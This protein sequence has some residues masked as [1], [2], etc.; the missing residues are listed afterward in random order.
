[1]KRIVEISASFTGK[2]S[3][4]SYENSSPYYALKEVYEYEK[5][6]LMYAT[7]LSDEQV[8]NRQNELHA[9]CYQQFKRHA[10]LAYS[11]KI[12]KTYRNIRFY[13]GKDGVKYPSVT[14]IIG[15]DAD[16][17][18]SPE[19]L[20][21]YGARGTIIDKQVEIYLTTGQWKEPKDI[22]EIYP[23]MVT[24]KGGNLSLVVDD[25]NFIDFYKNYPFKVI[26]LQGTILN[27]DHK[28]G[29]RYDIKCII[30]STNKGKWEKIDGVIFDKPTILDVKSGAM[31]KTKFLKQQNAYSKCE[32][33]V[34]QFGIIHLNN[35]TKQGYS[36]PIIETNLD[37]YFS[38]FLKD[39]ENFRN[40][41]GI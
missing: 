33:D 1:M 25:I 31:D 18:V 12:A 2:I 13:D 20:A 39:R 9:F 3:T 4:G 24:L 11:E 34:V 7:A 15:W 35:E 22:P 29:G 8:Q 32:E 10:D 19:E 17:H 21:Q 27:H 5:D 14:S 38:L 30:E 23:D 28:Y 36:Q 37:K 16:F 6:D 26:S 40:R 41:Y